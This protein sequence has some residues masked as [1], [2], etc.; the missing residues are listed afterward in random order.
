MF[1]KKTYLSKKDLAEAREL[2]RLSSS[3]RFVATLVKN[4]TALIPQGKKERDKYAAIANLI[5]AHKNQYVSEALVRAGLAL[6]QK[7]SIDFETGLITPI[8]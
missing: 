6:E 4:N 1:Q 2:H 5:D 7:A 8:E 3:Y